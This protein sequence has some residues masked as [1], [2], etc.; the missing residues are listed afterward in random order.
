MRTLELDYR[1]SIEVGDELGSD[2]ENCRYRYVR[3]SGH[4]THLHFKSGP[5]KNGLTEEILLAIIADRIRYFMKA[6]PS[7]VAE[8][9]LVEKAQELFRFRRLP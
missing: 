6:D 2:G 3:P 4:T 5:E 1:G 9:D 8:L 7:F